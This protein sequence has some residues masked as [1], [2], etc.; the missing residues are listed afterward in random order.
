MLVVVDLSPAEFVSRQQSGGDW[1]LLDVRERW[2]IEAA[3]IAGSVNIP[4]AEISSRMRELDSDRPV[5]V[6]CHSGVRSLR[7]AEFLEQQG[8]TT[9]ANIRGGIDAW[10]LEIDNTVPRY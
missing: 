8:F 5:A 3:S 9:V 2:E 6:I 4:M 7:V 1:S 10:S